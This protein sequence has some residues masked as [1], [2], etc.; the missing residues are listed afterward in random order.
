[1]AKPADYWQARDLNNVSYGGAI[2]D[3]VMQKIWDISG[4]PLPFTDMVA[5]GSASNPLV[6]WVQDK[7][8]APVAGGWVVDGS[9]VDQN[10][11]GF[12]T[13]YGNQCGIL[14]QEVQVSQR[15]DAVD[16]IAHQRETARNV[17]RRLQV[18]KRNI[19]ANA[20][21]HSLP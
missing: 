2:N 8:P 3:D 6:E 4:I 18:I 17:T 19:E 7:L 1:M 20:L 12:G 15:A 5:S 21:G 13:R 10:N 16:V 9:D 11:T 14:V